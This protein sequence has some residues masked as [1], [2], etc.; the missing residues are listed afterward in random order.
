MISSLKELRPSEHLQDGDA[1]IQAS[2]I[3]SN[4]LA[5]AASTQVVWQS[6]GMPAHRSSAGREEGRPKA[7]RLLDFAG[8]FRPLAFRACPDHIPEYANA[9]R[10][11]RLFSRREAQST[12]TELVEVGDL[13]CRKIKPDRAGIHLF[14][15]RGDGQ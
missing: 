5:D 1:S 15:T 9:H 3:A 2:G 7:S 6:A 10:P 8:S 14:S 13:S 4:G 11:N 12:S